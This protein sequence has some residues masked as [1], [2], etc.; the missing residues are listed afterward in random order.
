MRRQAVGRHKPILLP[1]PALLLLAAACG[2][3]NED[4]GTGPDPG[5]GPGPDSP[6]PAGLVFTVGPGVTELH[7]RIG[8]AVE[9][10]VVDEAGDPIPAVT[11]DVSLSLGKNPEAAGLGSG[12]TVSTA[13]DGVARFDDLA[14]DRRGTGYTLVASAEGVP[15]AE[16]DPF[17]IVFAW[18][19]VS[20]GAHHSCG[21]TSSGAAYCWGANAFGQLGD[22]SAGADEDADVPVAVATDLRFAQI[23]AGG[24][25]TCGLALDGSVYCWGANEQGQL[26]DGNAGT[27]SN[28]PRPVGL[29]ITFVRVSTGHSHVCGLTSIAGGDV[30]CW[31]RN[32]EGQLG[33]GT[34]MD[35][36]LPVKVDAGVLFTSVLASGVY[37]CAGELPNI[38]CWGENEHGQLGDGTSNDSD[39]PVLVS[40]GLDFQAHANGALTLGNAH[41]CGLTVQLE[42]WCW[43]RNNRGQLGTGDGTSSLI[44]VLTEAVPGAPFQALTASDDH[45]CGVTSSSD[46]RQV[47]CWGWNGSGQL[48]DGTTTDRAVPTATEGASGFRSIDAGSFHTCGVTDAGEAFCW[49]FNGSGQLGN[50]ESGTNSSTLAGVLDPPAP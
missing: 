38:Y 4:A 39:T 18:A 47:Y 2:S 32:V 37:A 13:V 14:L 26:G 24:R 9:V 7:Q 27:N 45:T 15:D 30:F 34:G 35:S 12:T 6:V 43:G 48:G 31:G 50:G 25:S 8:P 36:D 44:P 42:T 3:G 23:D 16:S 40:G 17:D 33:D 28:T 5:P 41:A 22:G 46:G 10:T 29:D 19:S 49:G 21:L 20:A 1:V 11:L